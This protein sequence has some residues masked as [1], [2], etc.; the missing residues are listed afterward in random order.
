MDEYQQEFIT[1]LKKY[2]KLRNFSQE[3]LAEFCEVSTGTIGNLE[4]GLAKPSFDLLIRLGIVLGIHPA[5]L[6][7][8]T[9]LDINQQ[10]NAEEHTLLFEIY[11]RLENHF[12]NSAK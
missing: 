12:K 2:R 6:L 4:C 10:M 5:H 7:S 3:K 11:K 1:N 9:P 8:D